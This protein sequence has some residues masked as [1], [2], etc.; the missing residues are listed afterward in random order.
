MI[1]DTWLT[2]PG[3]IQALGVFDLDPCTPDVM[4]WETARVRYTIKENGLASPWFGRVWLNP[5]YGREAAKWLNKMTTH[6]NG[7]ALIFARTETKDFFRYVWDQADGLLFI[8]GR[9]FFHH[10]GGTKAKAN[11]GAPSVL[12]GYGRQNANCLESCGIPG[13]YVPLNWTPVIVVGISPSWFSVVSIAVRHHGETDLTP[14]YQMVERIAPDKVSKNPHWK[15]KV[16]QQVQRYR[17]QK[18]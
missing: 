17:K 7:V 12:I 13:K 5:P 8:K 10:A 3:I 14:V 9:L 1:T 4:P 15:E 16:R 6:N 2:P 18:Q 11:A